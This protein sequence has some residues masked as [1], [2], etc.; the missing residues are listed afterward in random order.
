MWLGY[1]LSLEDHS[2]CISGKH[3]PTKATSSKMTAA[4][5]G[6]SLQWR[7]SLES[8][9][10]PSCPQVPAVL[11]GPLWSRS[12][13]EDMGGHVKYE[14]GQHTIHGSR[15]LPALRPPDPGLWGTSFTKSVS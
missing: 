4:V 11:A 9:P 8:V 15:C 14:S 3:K 6:D 2:C 5:G 13:A 7:A 1:R 12:A 10:H